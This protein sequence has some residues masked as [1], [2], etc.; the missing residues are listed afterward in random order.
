MGEGEPASSVPGNVWWS[1]VFPGDL[2]RLGEVRGWVR[3]LLPESGHRGD[4][5]LAAS[6]LA[7]N[8]V[9]HTRSGAEGGRFTVEVCGAP[10]WTRVVVGDQGS[11]DSA[12][13]VVE[14][15][16]LFVVRGLSL[17]WGTA[18]DEEARYVWADVVRPGDAAAV[19]A[20][21]GCGEAEI[22]E[23]L[24]RAFSGLRAWWGPQTRKWWAVPGGPGAAGASLDAPSPYALARMLGA[25]RAAAGSSGPAV[26]YAVKPSFTPR[27][28]PGGPWPDQP[29][30]GRS[31]GVPGP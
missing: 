13:H 29:G 27:R 10:G 15:H 6:E 26:P 12:P 20:G 30:T 11:P 4:V 9:R 31:R 24:V 28:P 14:Q 18:G 23:R 16:G 19:P 21:G 17:V 25:W 5:V 22:E 3:G 2:A 1:G 7:A 8:A